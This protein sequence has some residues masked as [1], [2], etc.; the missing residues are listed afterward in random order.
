MCSS[1]LKPLE[2]GHE[3]DNV[4]R[5]GNAKSLAARPMQLCMARSR[6]STASKAAD[7]ERLYNSI[8]ACVIAILDNSSADSLPSPAAEQ[9]ISH[10]SRYHP[11]VEDWSDHDDQETS[12]APVPVA[13]RCKVT[14]TSRQRSRKKADSAKVAKTGFK[15]ST[16]RDIQRPV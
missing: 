7:N 16:A 10:V 4:S 15:A 3:G 6:R 8:D 14:L 2:R 9:H 12:E 13:S 11:F 1:D 5:A